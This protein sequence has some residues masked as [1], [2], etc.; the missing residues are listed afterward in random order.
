MSIKLFI[1]NV[2]KSRRERRASAFPIRLSLHID[3]NSGAVIPW[4]KL[5]SSFSPDGLSRFWVSQSTLC[6]QERSQSLKD[7]RVKDGHKSLVLLIAHSP[8]RCSADVELK[9]TIPSRSPSTSR[10]VTSESSEYVLHIRGR[11]PC[12]RLLI[13]WRRRSRMTTWHNRRC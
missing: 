3:C 8:G 10:N 11:L 7:P 12:W 1:H 9:R 13:I 5:C 4:N 2:Q 6:C